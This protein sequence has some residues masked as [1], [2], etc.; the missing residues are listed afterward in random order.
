MGRNGTTRGVVDHAVV[1]LPRAGRV[2]RLRDVGG[3]SERALHLGA[4]SVAF[5]R[6]GVVGAGGGRSRTSSRVVRS[7]AVVVAGTRTLLARAAD[8]A[9]PR[10]LPLHLLLL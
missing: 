5:L 7:Q 8:P 4:V 9:V 3:V 2:H 6:A 10:P 1:R